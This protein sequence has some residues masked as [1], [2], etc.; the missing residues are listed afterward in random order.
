[1]ANHGVLFSILLSDKLCH[2]DLQAF[3]E[4]VAQESQS[5]DLFAICSVCSHNAFLDK[6]NST[7]RE[8]KVHS[9]FSA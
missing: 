6:I 5:F 1:M 4:S 2:F 3:V 9:I 7:S 8:V